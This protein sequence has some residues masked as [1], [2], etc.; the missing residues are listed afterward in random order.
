MEK[1]TQNFIV[2]L[3]KKPVKYFK[4]GLLYIVLH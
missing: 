1:V 3:E 4:S 2:I